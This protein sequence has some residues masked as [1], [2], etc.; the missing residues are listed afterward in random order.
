MSAAQKKV[1]IDAV[2]AHL[3]DMVYDVNVDADRR[4]K[5]RAI[6]EKNFTFIEGGKDFEDLMTKFRAEQRVEM[7][8]IDAKN[9]GVP[10]ADKIF[11][12]FFKNLAK[13]EKIAKEKNLMNDKKAMAAAYKT[14][15]YDKLDPSKL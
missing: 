12:I 1:A 7:P 9:L 4:L 6:K 15:I 5:E 14:E 11:D 8:K 2:P 3:A 10:N 13:W